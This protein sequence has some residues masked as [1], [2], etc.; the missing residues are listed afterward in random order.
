[1]QQ[2]CDVCGAPDAGPKVCNGDGRYH[3]HGRV[4]TKLWGLD[5]LCAECYAEDRAAWGPRPWDTDGG[6]G[7]KS[8]EHLLST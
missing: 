6:D 4:H 3:Y 5:R 1:M 8:I 7:R 2:R